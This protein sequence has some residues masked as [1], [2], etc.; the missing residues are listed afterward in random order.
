[1]VYTWY[2]P[3]IYLV[4]VPDESRMCGQARLVDASRSYGDK[5]SPVGPF[6]SVY[7]TLGGVLAPSRKQ[8][9]IVNQNGCDGML[10]SKIEYSTQMTPPELT[11]IDPYPTA[12]QSD[13]IWTR[14]R[15]LN[16]KRRRRT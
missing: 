11:P 12:G 14:W 7:L 6:R 13:A 1:M 5:L 15:Q 3:T 8:T 9:S 10:S 16:G 4:G 2:I